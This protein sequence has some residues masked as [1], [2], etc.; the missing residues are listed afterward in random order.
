MGSLGSHDHGVKDVYSK[1]AEERAKRIRP[2]GLAQYT[3]AKDLA[4]FKHLADDPWAHEAG[5]RQWA[6]PAGS[7][8]GR[9]KVVIVG[10]GFGGLTYAIRFLL[11][12]NLNP[13]DILFVDNATGF[14]GAWYWNRYPG[15]M[16]DVESSCYMP[17]L[18]ETGYTPKDRYAYGSELRNYAEL[19]ASRWNL[20]DRALW[21]TTVRSAKW[22]DENSE[23]VLQVQKSSSDGTSTVV[24]VRTEYFV[25]TSGLLHNPKLPDVPGIGKFSKH[26]FHT[27]R[28]DYAYTGGS[29]DNP[30]MNKLKDKKVIF[31]GTGATAVQAVPHLAKWAKK[32]FVVQRTPASVDIRDQRKINSEEF[33]EKVSNHRGWQRRRRENMAAFISNAAEDVD[34]IT[35]SWMT[36][37][38]YSALV[39]GPNAKDLTDKTAND[40]INNL[41]AIDLERQDRIRA[42]VDSIVEDHK[43]AQLLKPWYSGWCKRPCF[44]DDYL[45]AFNQ[46]N[47]Q[48]V[49]TKG[50]GIESCTENG[51]ICNGVVYDAD[52]VIFGTGF[53]PWT[54]GSPSQRAGFKILGRYGLDMNNK[55]ENGIGTLHGLMSR[56][57]PNLF[58]SGV[59]QT[60]AT[61]NYAH[62]VDVAAVHAAQIVASVTAKTHPGK[63]RP[64]IE[65]TAEGEDN[66]TRRIVEMAF[67]YAGFGGC[68]PSYTTAEGQATREMSPE[69]SFKAAMGLNWGS[70]F[71]DYIKT[72]ENW[73]ANGKLEGLDVQIVGD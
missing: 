34:L 16:C 33:K 4:K 72:I 51:I 24:D 15:L 61:V 45:P 7:Q 70:G 19:L 39:G 37:P 42:R 65:P 13:S 64:V 49:D 58:I 25:L 29:S 1:Y 36:F 53:E 60:G 54:S 67:A 5:D 3:N 73:R 44:H 10:T 52:V 27:A 62:M 63:T 38:S 32:L 48:L 12:A 56:G 21:R 59:N 20:Q 2:E 9:S 41:Q 17:L 14:G 18:E 57:F 22:D 35:D 71:L 46:S 11:E 47:V 40:Y 6:W 26:T 66:W 43:T 30:M 50:R 69:E 55:W 8:N 31:V 68:T 23:W 28:W